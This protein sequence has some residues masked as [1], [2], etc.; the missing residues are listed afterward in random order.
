MGTQQTGIIEIQDPHGEVVL[1]ITVI[2]ND[3]NVGMRMTS[4]FENLL[5]SDR[6]TA[7]R[8]CSIHYS[9]SDGTNIWRHLDYEPY[10][11]II[12]NLSHD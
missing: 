7:I 1:S 11:P 4:C 6:L 8:A 12:R 2:T 10:R 9:N 3:S 5:G